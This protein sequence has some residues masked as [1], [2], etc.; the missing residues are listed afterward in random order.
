MR[1]SLCRPM[2]VAV[3]WRGETFRALVQSFDG[4]P[5]ED[6]FD[7]KTLLHTKKIWLVNQIV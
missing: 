4:G 1:M 2:T 6:P 3:Q 5:L 7:E